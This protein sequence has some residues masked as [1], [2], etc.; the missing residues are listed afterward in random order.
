VR[1]TNI[2]GSPILASSWKGV[3]DTKDAHYCAST[4]IPKAQCTPETCLQDP[5]TQ[6]YGNCDADDLCPEREC[7][8]AGQVP[9]M[10]S[11]HGKFML[12]DYGQP[13]LKNYRGA[14]TGTAFAL[15]ASHLT[16]VEEF[17]Y[18]KSATIKI[19]MF[20]DPYNPVDPPSIAGSNW[21]IVIAD[22]RPETPGNGIRIPQSEQLDKFI[23]SATIVMGGSSLTL[24]LY[25]T[26]PIGPDGQPLKNMQIEAVQSDNY[27]G[28]I[29]LCID[30]QT[31]D[32]LSVEQYESMDVIQDW[33]DGHPGSR[34]A[35]DILTRFSAFGE[36]PLLFA[37]KNA[38]VVL[39][40]G[41]GSGIGRITHIEMYDTTL[42]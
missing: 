34:T 6:K 19:P 9:P 39:D 4:L 13:L 26:H 37:A 16:L 1:I 41:A 5:A 10:D 28:N 31:G 8:K 7:T 24:D 12:D 25:Y 21:P 17:P 23:P 15:G 35:C 11:A 30:D 27:M 18:I 14:F 29:F 40:V 3:S 22:W 2:V 42:Q 20:P 33:L 36:Y 38:G 32:L